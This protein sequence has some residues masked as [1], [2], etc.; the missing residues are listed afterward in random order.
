MRSYTFQTKNTRNFLTEVE[1][2]LAKHPELEPTK[3]SYGDDCHRYKLYSGTELFMEIDLTRLDEAYSVDI[4][5]IVFWEGMPHLFDELETKL[6]PKYAK[7][8]IFDRGK[9]SDRIFRIYL[10]PPIIAEIDTELYPPEVLE[11]GEDGF[12]RIK[13]GYDY[14]PLKLKEYEDRLDH[15]EGAEMALVSRREIEPALTPNLLNSEILEGVFTEVKAV[16]PSNKRGRK[17]KD[18]QERAERVKEFIALQDK[19][20]NTRDDWDMLGEMMKPKVSKRTIER[21]IEVLGYEV[22]DNKIILPSTLN[23]IN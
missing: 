6:C 17:A 22:R 11:L 1:K 8:P 7:G 21:D 20:P 2:V 5:Q 18:L 10:H 12:Y 19:Y 13:A 16:K 4:A 14:P 23:D 15:I 3:I 9:W